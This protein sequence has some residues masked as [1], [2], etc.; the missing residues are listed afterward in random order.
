MDDQF[1]TDADIIPMYTC[2]ECKTAVVVHD[3]QIIR[4][5]EHKDAPVLASLAATCYGES[6]VTE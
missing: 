4:V 3:N 1:R 2:A 6:E 5:C